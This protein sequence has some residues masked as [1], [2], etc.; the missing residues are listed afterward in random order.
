MD[1]AAEPKEAMDELEELEGKQGAAAELK[2][3]AKRAAADAAAA[4]KEQAEADCEGVN[5]VACRRTSS[6]NSHG[7]SECSE[8]TPVKHTATMGALTA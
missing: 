1:A 8:W 6:W 4:A 2:A 3:A 5:G 7:V